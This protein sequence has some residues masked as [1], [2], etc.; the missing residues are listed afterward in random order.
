M[1]SKLATIAHPLYINWNRA[2]NA[3]EGFTVFCFVLFSTIRNKKIKFFCALYVLE[4][5]H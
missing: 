1:K 5:S 4:Q 2:V 3:D